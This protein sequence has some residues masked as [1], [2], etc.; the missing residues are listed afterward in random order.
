MLL[1]FLLIIFLNSLNLI[2]MEIQ[3]L[4]SIPPAP[5]G[6]ARKKLRFESEWKKNKTKTK[7]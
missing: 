1:V 4:E 3:Q 7:R 5:K 2:Q 6:K